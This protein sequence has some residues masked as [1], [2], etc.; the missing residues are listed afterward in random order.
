MNPLSKTLARIVLL[1]CLAAFTEP[2]AVAAQQQ[3]ASAEQATPPATQAAPA[4]PQAAPVP[5]AAGSQPAGEARISLDL[6]NANLTD[7]IRIIA[8][9][10][11]MNYVV[12]PAVKGIVNVTT[13][14]D[15][16][17]EDLLG[18][19][20]TIL[21]ANGAVAVESG[22]FWRIVQAAN[23]PRVPVAVSRNLAA[24]NIPEDDRMVMN[25]V[26]LAYVTAADMSE[27]LKTY[28]SEAGQIVRYDPGN[29]LLITETSRSMKR[30][31]DLVALF[32]TDALA[33]Q[34]LRL[35][36]VENAQASQLVLDLRDIFSAYALSDKSAVK[37]LPIG[38]INSILVVSGNPNVFNEVQQW[39]ERLDKPV[40]KTGIQNFVYRVE[41][42]SA[43]NLAAVLNGLYGAGGGVPQ[44]RPQAGT[45]ALSAAGTMSGFGTPGYGGAGM[46]GGLGGGATPGGAAGQMPLAAGM[47]SAAAAQQPATSEVVALPGGMLQSGVRI[48]ADTVNNALIIQAT[49]QDYE[50]IRQTL[51]ELDTVPRQV[52]IEAKVYEVTLT[53]ALSFG[54][55]YFLEHRSE[56][57]R[58]AVG[59][60]ALG[61]NEGRAGLANPG[62]SLSAGTLVGRSRELLAF[63]NAQENRSRTKVVSAPTVLASD[64]QEARIQV[65]A[66]VPILTSQGVMAGAQMG[67]TSVFTNTVQQRDTGV[68]LSVVPRINSSG[69]VSLR[70][71]QEVSQALA[72]TVGTI[73]SPT[74][75]KR[76]VLTQ[77]TV[78][79]GET[80]AL[81][82]IISEN[83]LFS[84]N[85]IP[86]LGD[87]PVLGVLFGSTSTTNVRT[88]LIVLLTPRVIQTV[89]GAADATNEFRDRLKEIKKAFKELSDDKK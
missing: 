71:G 15:L 24:G 80:I 55:E 75:Q 66:E 59:Q 13:M 83:N 41:N 60:F 84:K 53:G 9:E 43:E 10:L 25:V 31:M 54:V 21:R 20:Q 8:A 35:F 16:R 79:D 74:I 3:P 89:A 61:A 63:L 47:P 30:L 86:L 49:P 81:G 32:D 40:R 19:L 65:G 6:A 76:S 51:K 27:I 4:T 62:L 70:I 50:I 26:P 38:R 1:S 88:E 82:G 36:P 33:Q 57:D 58:R 73:Q 7:V 37:F 14:G 22:G 5:P 46:A 39:V 78:Q 34:R 52:M 72:P 42:A 17:Q 18:L 69:L 45:G 56:Q 87:I 2:H 64:N 23:A 67:G 68:I 12:D 11:K 28:L 29:V 85:R 77:A 48:V 44:T